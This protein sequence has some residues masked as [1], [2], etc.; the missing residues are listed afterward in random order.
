LAEKLISS[1]I[2]A[3]SCRTKGYGA[4]IASAYE[5][6]RECGASR[7]GE[8]RAFN[9]NLPTIQGLGKTLT[10]ARYVCR[11]IQWAGAYGACSDLTTT[12]SQNGG[13]I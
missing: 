4:Q 1:N 7:D 9:L 6:L 5:S 2:P 12:K 13:V 3:Y 11:G 10:A 8:V